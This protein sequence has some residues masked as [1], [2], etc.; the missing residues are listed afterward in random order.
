MTEIDRAPADTD[1]LVAKIAAGA[2][3]VGYTAKAWS[4]GG[5]DRVYVTR[6]GR[7]DC[8]YI[9]IR[10]D[11]TLD[12][13]ALKVAGVSDDSILAA[14]VTMTRVR[15]YYETIAPGG[16]R[17]SP[18]ARRRLIREHL[19]ASGHVVRVEVVCEVA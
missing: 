4:K 13:G 1:S 3:G 8:G 15:T 2:L 18:A 7:K 11:G 17:R 19:D 6:Y 10:T 5:H 9:A 16:Y 12:L 14:L